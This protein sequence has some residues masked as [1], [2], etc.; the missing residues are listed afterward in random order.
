MRPFIA[1]CCVAIGLQT[2]V[3]VDRLQAGPA[4]RVQTPAAAGASAAQV[5]SRIKVSVPHEEAE[6]LVNGNAVGGAGTTR[7]FQSP[8]LDLG[9]KYDYRFT[10]K[11]RPNNYT[12]I[13]RHKTIRF[14]GGDEATA[15]LTTDDPSDRAEIRYVPTPADTVRQMIELAR[16]NKNDVVYE[17]GCGDARITIAAVKAGAKKGIGIDLDPARVAESKANVQAA[18]LEDRIDIRLGDALDI[19][20]L[21]EATVVFLYMG[22][23]FDK[24]I[25]PILWKQLKVGTRIVS[26]RFTMG[27]WPPDRSTLINGNDDETYSNLHLWTITQEVKERA[28][29]N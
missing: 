7:E 12:V 16:V 8:P 4:S 11:W 18:G 17:P 29:R 26:H 10:V 3:M 24:L 9:R 22:D 20:D 2:V 25:R 1:A 5:R 28:G 6:L 21:S 13:T 14:T 15:D 19:K 23:E 27:D